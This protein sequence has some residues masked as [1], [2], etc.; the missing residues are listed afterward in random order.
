M[1]LIDTILSTENNNPKANL[2]QD[3]RLKFASNKQRNQLCIPTGKELL[4]K[5][6]TELQASR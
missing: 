6:T 3:P 2:F 5:N 4:E 1:H